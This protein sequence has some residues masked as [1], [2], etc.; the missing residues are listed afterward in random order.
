MWS[1]NCTLEYN[2]LKCQEYN[3]QLTSYVLLGTDKNILQLAEFYLVSHKC[4]IFVYH[5]TP[6]R[7]C[8][9]SRPRFY[10]IHTLFFYSLF[11]IYKNTCT[12]EPEI[13]V[14]FVFKICL[15]QKNRYA[16]NGLQPSSGLKLKFRRS[17]DWFENVI[18]DI[19]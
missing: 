9:P 8:T 3:L 6:T 18:H 14:F 1:L 7:Y 12:V 19:C 10:A 16:V 5:H 13:H 11:F 15:P 17:K 4:K 2:T